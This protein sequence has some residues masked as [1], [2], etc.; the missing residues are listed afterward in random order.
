MIK[1][2]PAIVEMDLDDSDENR[3]SKKKS[4]VKTMAMSNYRNNP[5]K[6]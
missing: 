1:R 2:N 5:K 6:K 3:R 4:V